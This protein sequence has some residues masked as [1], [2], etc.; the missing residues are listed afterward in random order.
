MI[1][2]QVGHLSRLVDDLLE[3]SRVTLGRIELLRER[4]SVALVVEH[5][6]EAA[7]TAIEEGGHQLQLELPAVPLWVDA[8]LVRL[9][10]VYTNL[11]TN[12]ARY[13]PAGGRITLRVYARG[14][15]AVVSVEDTGI[16]IAPEMLGHVFEMFVQVPHGDRARHG[17]LGIGL[18][19]SKRLV[20]LHGGTIEAWSQ[21]EGCGSEFRVLMPRA[22]GRAPRRSPSS[23]RPWWRRDAGSSWSTT[24]W[25]RR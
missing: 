20:E 4:V 6:V 12:A 13:T 5:A 11:L 21:G 9:S 16:G 15:D 17:G 3:V 25:T 19:L 18:A 22:S 23:A 14:G 8:D 24:T 2:R 1:E 7:R 10:Q